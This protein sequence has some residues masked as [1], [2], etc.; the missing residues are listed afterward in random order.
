MY[1]IFSVSIIFF[2]IFFNS[3]SQGKWINYKNNNDCSSIAIDADTVW[4]GTKDGSIVKRNINGNMLKT[5]NKIDELF[6]N[7]IY[8]IAIDSQGNKWFGTWGGGVSKFDGSTWTTYKT[9]GVSSCDVRSIAIDQQGNKWFG[10]DCGVSEFI[11][12]NIVNTNDQLKN[13]KIMTIYP[14]PAS[15]LV[16]LNIGS[17][18]YQNGISEDFEINIYN[19]MG[20]LVKTVILK[21]NQKQINIGNLSNGVYML[22]IKSKSLTATKKLIIQK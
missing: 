14:N 3:F 22:T 18:S 15:D 1:K 7:K 2:F 11:E 19:L 20:K 8:S 5:L 17:D 16:S 9:N 4:I 6:N 21:Q 13:E 10:T 12:N